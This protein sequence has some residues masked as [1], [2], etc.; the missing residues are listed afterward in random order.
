[1]R[2]LVLVA[3]S[4]VASVLALGT[5]CEGVPD[6]RFADPADASVTQPAVPTEDGS[7]STGGGSS[8]G[9]QTDSAVS[10]DASGSDSPSAPPVDAA[11]PPDADTEIKYAPVV[12]ERHRTARRKRTQK[13]RTVLRKIGVFVE[14]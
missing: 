2:G 11:Q 4:L 13:H 12:A 7:V 10:E 6:L 9:G 3:T 14:T 5:G 1:M 8:S